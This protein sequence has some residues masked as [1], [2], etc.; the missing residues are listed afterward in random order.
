VENVTGNEFSEILKAKSLLSTA[1]NGELSIMSSSNK[2][3][4]INQGCRG[5]NINEILLPRRQSLPWFSITF[6][7]ISLTLI[8]L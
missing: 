1:A 7:I 6:F 4:I 8:K 2:K 5:G 3:T